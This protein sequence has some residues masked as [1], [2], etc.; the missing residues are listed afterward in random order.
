MQLVDL[1]FGER[2]SEVRCEASISVNVQSTDWRP[3]KGLISNVSQSGVFISSAGKYKVG[4][5]ISLALPGV[6]VRLA[7]VVRASFMRRYGCEFIK[8]LALSELSELV[9]DPQ[10]SWIYIGKS[11]LRAA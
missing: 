7:R 10:S 3:Y 1:E 4:D 2:R 5:V 9:A 6:G 8:P 11:V